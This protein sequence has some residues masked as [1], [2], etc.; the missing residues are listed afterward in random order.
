MLF[1][2]FVDV[3]DEKQHLCTCWL[4]GKYWYSIDGTPLDAAA[5]PPRAPC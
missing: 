2:E 3:V 1:D 5:N 4:V